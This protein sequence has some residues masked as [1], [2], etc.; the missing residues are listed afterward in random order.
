MWDRREAGRWHG[1]GYDTDS[2]ISHVLIP[3]HGLLILRG[4]P[5]ELRL[6]P[7]LLLIV[8]KDG[9]TQ[10]R[11]EIRLRRAA[12]RGQVLGEEKNWHP[13]LLRV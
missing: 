7:G 3:H 1:L 9:L 2:L 11:L 5:G 13:P 8:R 4:S 6:P 12:L 10:L